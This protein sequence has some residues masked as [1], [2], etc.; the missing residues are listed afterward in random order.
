MTGEKKLFSWKNMV[1]IGIA[2]C[3]G[4]GINGYRTYR[5]EG[6]LSGTWFAIAG[7]TLVIVFLIAA[8]VIRH[9]NRPE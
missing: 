5:N 3:L 2:A 8:L 6:H 1:L 4:I 7:A 9:G